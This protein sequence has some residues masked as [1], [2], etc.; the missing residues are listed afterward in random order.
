VADRAQYCDLI[1][2]PRQ[3][4]INILSLQ[5]PGPKHFRAN[6]RGVPMTMISIVSMRSVSEAR[7][8]DHSP[9]TIALFCCLGLVTSV[10]LMTF[11]IDLSAGWA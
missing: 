3:S 4:L 8:G 2:D 10:C 11:G 9:K 5:P 6:K 7:A 1:N